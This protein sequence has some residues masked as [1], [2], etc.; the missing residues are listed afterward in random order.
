MKAST[1]ALID[2]LGA[3]C[4]EARR[5]VRDGARHF[6]TS[7]EL[8][9]R[10]GP[11]AASLLEGS[12]LRVLAGK[13]IHCPHVSGSPRAV[14]LLGWDRRLLCHACARD[15]LAAVRG[16]PEDHVCDVCRRAD[17]GP[18]KTVLAAAGPV[19]LTFGCCP[20]CAV[21]EAPEVVR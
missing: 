8:E 7:H 21:A 9:Q 4:Q 16:T 2:Q 19:M 15:A 13:S 3:A 18:L 12:L 11:F 20:A 14:W 1:T 6:D 5:V 10:P 17:R